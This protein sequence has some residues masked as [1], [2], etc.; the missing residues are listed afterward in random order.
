LGRDQSTGSAP[1]NEF[2]RPSG[3]R[4][5]TE[6][7]VVVTSQ[8]TDLDV[9]VQQVVGLHRQPPS[10]GEVDDV[11]SAAH[12]LL[13]AAPPDIRRNKRE[14]NTGIAALWPMPRGMPLQFEAEGSV[15]SNSWWPNARWNACLGAA[16]IAITSQPRVGAVPLNSPRVRSRSRILDWS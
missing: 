4:V 3:H 14:G 7:E 2:R 5:E 15:M 13:S 11:P 1:V 9:L 12:L 8:A 16:A 10:V 6:F